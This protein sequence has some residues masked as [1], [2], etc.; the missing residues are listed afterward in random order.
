MNNRNY[1][2]NYDLNE[3]NKRIKKEQTKWMWIILVCCF[4]IQMI[5]YCIA[6]NLNNVFI[7]SDW[8]Q[9]VEGKNLFIGLG[10]TF[11]SLLSAIISPYIAKL[12]GKNINPR[13]IYSVGLVLAMIGFIFP[14]LISIIYKTTGVKLLA[15]GSVVPTL[16]LAIGLSQVGS[17]IFSGLGVNNLISKWWPA[18]K[19][20]FALGIAFA[21]SSI[22]VIWIKQVLNILANIFGN[23][24]PN[25]A[26]GIKYNLYGNQFAT[27]LIIGLFGLVFGLLLI[28][29][30]C[31]RP[32]PTIESLETSSIKKEITSNKIVINNVSPI[33][34]KKY[35][36]YWVLGFGYLL[37]QIGSVHSSLNGLFIV[38]TTCVANTDV[39]Y[40]DIV[41]TGGSIFGI[42]AI[43][44]SLF[45]SF[46]N[47]RTKPYKMLILGG[48]V[49]SIAIFC[50]LYSVKLPTLTYVYF[51][52]A[53]FSSFLFTIM[54]AYISGRLYGAKYSNAHMAILS[55][56]LAVGFAIINSVSGFITGNAGYTSSGQIINPHNMFGT[57][58]SGNFLSLGIILLV[59]MLFGTL[60][61]S[62]CCI[63]IRQK[64]IQGLLDYTPSKYSKI[65]NLK[66]GFI[67]KFYALI[68]Y[69]TKNDF[70]KSQKWLN[71][72]SKYEK[73]DKYLNVYDKYH[74]VFMEVY[75]D[76][77][78]LNDEKI[79][80]L[81]RIYF[82]NI[83]LYRRILKIYSEK[84]IN[85]END[86]NF[87]LENNYISRR[88]II[89]ESYYYYVT[90]EVYN[91]VRDKTE[92]LNRKYE[93]IDFENNRI[94]NVLQKI[95][96]NNHS[97][98]E[99]YA[100]RINDL[101]S[102]P[103]EEKELEKICKK[104]DKLIN[105]YTRLRDK[106]LSKNSLTEWKKFDI[107]SYYTTKINNLILL[108]ETMS[109]QREQKIKSL[110]LRKKI[111][112]RNLLVLKRQRIDG[113]YLLMEYI[114]N[115]Y[116]SINSFIDLKINELIDQKNDDLQMNKKIKEKSLNK[117]K[118]KILSIFNK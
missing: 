31:K 8:N 45:A 73:H 37:I 12:F 93:K 61:V 4:F 62:I 79:E 13:I 97:K 48:V 16:W 108:K 18:E 20:G 113:H 82:Y 26:A 100:K 72:I 90:R 96:D 76:D 10:F 105:K 75:S 85:I 80:L 107:D 44:G 33:E 60:V 86:L 41:G 54:P 106:K 42:T 66:Y 30:A 21:G 99:V 98:V 39:N 7:G 57:I 114:N 34:V 29:I 118:S 32:I 14:G 53:G 110:I 50:L 11:G 1:I 59:C 87:L 111:I 9:W 102:S 77:K 65:M 46:V 22:G 52:F 104:S 101:K 94:K 67:S 55:I 70:R 71:K 51:G 35:I 23:I 88:E 89:D 64:G 6:V 78:R 81:S 69:Y 19:R 116:K 95:R 56:F 112:K 3:I 27:Y 40:N 49:Q 5:P 83:I 115:K 117:V 38:N 103:E 68:I 92:E 25:P 91:K 63:L 15:I 2:L 109:H 47:D 84:G 28:L 24:A 58:V 17:M 74:E 43:A 36:P